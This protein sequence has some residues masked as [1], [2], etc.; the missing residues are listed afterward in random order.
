MYN[1]PLPTV[2]TMSSFSELIQDASELR[3]QIDNLFSSIY[4]TISPL[5]AAAV[6]NQNSGSATNVVFGANSITS[7]VGTTVA[8]SGGNQIQIGSVVAIGN[9]TNG[10]ANIVSS[11]SSNVS[12]TASSSTQTNFDLNFAGSTININAPLTMSGANN[13]YSPYIGPA[14]AL[15]EYDASDTNHSITLTHPSQVNFKTSDKTVANVTSSGVT[16]NIATGF[17]SYCNCYASN[18]QF[19]S[20]GT[21]GLNVTNGNRGVLQVP[22]N[23][24]VILSAA[25]TN[26][27][28]VTSSGVSVPGNLSIQGIL[29]VSSYPSMTYNDFAVVQLGYNQLVGFK[30]N[31]SQTY[32]LTTPLATNP[33]GYGYGAVARL[34]NNTYVASAL[35][36]G[37]TQQFPI[38]ITNVT[39]SS[40]RMYMPFI[41]R[42]QTTGGNNG[43]VKMPWNSYNPTG[44]TFL[45]MNTY[46]TVF[47]FPILSSS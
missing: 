44:E 23:G 36:G 3:T 1:I 40:F 35:V 14:N 47:I 26:A 5:L 21:V 41:V 42:F 10:V 32:T 43:Y 2:P 9:A 4:S 13:V 7:S 11:N 38:T 46:V 22:S 6:S 39:S 31:V 45:G 37:D 29:N 18:Y 30:T 8:T 17:Q 20:N 33:T 34:T 19:N 28:T 27:M 25:S 24:N 15:I 12:I 16:A